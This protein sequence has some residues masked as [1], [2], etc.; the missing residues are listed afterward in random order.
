MSRSTKVALLAL[1][2]AAVYLAAESFQPPERQLTARACLA[3][4]DAYQA[5][6]S[7]LLKSCGL[8][9]RYTPSCSHYAE[10]A[11]AIH[12]TV[13]G[14]ARTAGR[15]WRCSPWGGCGYDPVTAS[16]A[17][18]LQEEM[19]AQDPP[20]QETPEER[21]AREQ[22][23]RAAREIERAFKQMEDSAPEAA[24]GC[25]LAGVGCIIFTLVSIA[26]VVLIMV[27]VYKDAKARGDQNA[28]LWLVL[29]FFLGLIGLLIYVLARPKGE[30]AP[31]G[32]C[33]NKKL[34]TLM[35]CPH[36]GIEAGGGAIAK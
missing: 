22:A 27:W 14:L 13:P 1:F 4:V 35:K 7:P 11:I 16:R 15:L 31:C 10:E 32:N 30:L 5:A 20:A 28:V 2:G 26:V 18:T 8:Q 6:G 25:A 29:V 21:R 12:G 23:E 19:P 9:C 33:H 17:G 3:A 36:C 24:A 34:T